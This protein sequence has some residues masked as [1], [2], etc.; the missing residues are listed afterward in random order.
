[1]ND[2]VKRR[3]LNNQAPQKP[4]EPAEEL[5]APEITHDTDAALDQIRA[6]VGQVGVRP[7]MAQ[8]LDMLEYEK[9]EERQSPMK[10]MRPQVDQN[11]AA[12]I[13]QNTHATQFGEIYMFLSRFPSL[14]LYVE[15]EGT[16]ADGTV[17]RMNQPI[18]FKN[19]TFTTRDRNIAAAVRNHRRCNTV[20]F[21]EAPSQEAAAMFAAANRARANM[22]T[23]VQVGVVSAAQGNDMAFMQHE[24]QLG[25]VEDRIIQL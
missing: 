7:V 22:R 6:E 21:R 14:T 24:A 15:V 3:V 4:E 23:G 11:P 16:R 19:G 12:R 20:T 13:L 1:M 10:V 18:Q 17:G 9:A 8:P 5:A 2:E 25:N